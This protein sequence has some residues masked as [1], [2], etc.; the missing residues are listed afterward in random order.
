V[1]F[2]G[3]RGDVAKEAAAPFEGSV[4]L[5][6]DLSTVEGARA[7]HAA[8][9]DAVGPLDILILNGPGPRP[10]VATT[11][12]TDSITAAVT[13]LMLVHQAV[14]AEAL[15]HLLDSGWGRILGIGSSGVAAPI[16]GLSLS[17]I[18]RAAFAGY[19]KSLSNEIA[20][21]GT[22]VNLLLPGRI[23]T[24]RLRSLDAAAAERSG[25]PLEDVQKQLISAIPV[26]RYGDPDEFG[27]AAAFLCSAQASYITGI[28]MRCDGGL[29]PTL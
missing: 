6:A 17:N 10:G 8:A 11:L 29:V 25:S 18:G 12:D 19:L 15:P 23:A 20:S 3:R 5:E 24:D 4:G 22:T 26:G 16:T 13:S 9:V 2:S 21:R 1:V 7:L 14:V 27:A 28:A